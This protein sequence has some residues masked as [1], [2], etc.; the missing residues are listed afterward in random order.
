MKIVILFF[1]CVC[2]QSFSQDEKLVFKFYDDEY[3]FGQ[4]A[5]EYPKNFWFSFNEESPLLPQSI[6]YISLRGDTNSSV[7]GLFYEDK[8]CL[9]SIST[10]GKR[11]ENHPYEYVEKLIK[12]VMYYRSDS[13]GTAYK[14][15]DY[16][17]FVKS[18]PRMQMLIGP[19]KS[20]EKIRE[21]NTE[22]LKKFF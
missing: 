18:A 16:Y 13:D 5:S 10:S 7:V 15:D 11:R 14:T 6:V 19:V 3:I 20:V 12:G 9:I 8:L 1:F 17:V 4:A 21:T 2:S 22:Y